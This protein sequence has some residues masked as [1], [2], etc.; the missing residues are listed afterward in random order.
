M[1]AAG[2]KQLRDPACQNPNP[3]VINSEVALQSSWQAQDYLLCH[4]CEQMFRE[5]GE[6]WILCHCWRKEGFR[7]YEILKSATP[8]KI[9]G[10]LKIFSAASIPKI[11]VDQIGYFAASIV[12]R[13]CVHEWRS[14]KGRYQSAG[15]LGPY[16]E[17][18]RRYLLGTA[19]F[20]RNAALW[21]SV[22]ERNSDAVFAVVAPYHGRVR[23]C[24]AYRALFLGIGFD[25]FLGK[26]LDSSTR[27]M[28][29]IRGSPTHPMYLTD[30][31]DEHIGYDMARRIEKVRDLVKG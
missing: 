5:K 1:P 20:P 17:Q 22:S 16:E 29:F 10:R 21:V 30:M 18:F 12:W 24:H 26:N 14:G 15:S 2:F 3:V 4:D 9:E 25:L 28:C 6:D 7:L 19:E 27:S 23:G 8:S 11:D 13:A 31:L